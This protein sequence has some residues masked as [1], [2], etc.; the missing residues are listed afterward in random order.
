MKIEKISSQV[1]T[2]NQKFQIIEKIS[3]KDNNKYVY[4]RK[5]KCTKCGLE[6]IVSLNHIERCIC[7]DCKKLETVLSYEGKTFGNYTIIKYDSIKETDTYTRKLFLVKCNICGSESIQELSHLLSNPKSCS[8][9][10]YDTRLKNNPP[11]LIS[12]RNCI[13]STYLGGAK[14]RGLEFT[15]SDDKFDKL[16]LG[17]CVY[18]GAHPSEYQSDKKFNKTNEIFKRNGIDRID[19]NKGYTDDNCVSCCEMCNRMKSDYT[20]SEFI[21]HIENI[22]TFL[23]NKGST[24]ISKESTLQANGNGNGGH[25]TTLINVKDDDIV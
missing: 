12:V 14:N 16:I 24:T 7:P 20:V 17:D 3:D 15:L 6:Q 13:K 19:S 21:D 4:K 22:H 18:C 10:K 11:K 25:P 5:I 1:F 23:V 9:C 8:V 2:K